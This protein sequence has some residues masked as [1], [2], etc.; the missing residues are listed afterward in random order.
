ML[1]L[2]PPFASDVEDVAVAMLL[3]VEPAGVPEAINT[4]SVNCA[5]P[6]GNE[7]IEQ[8]IGPLLPPS[9]V[10]QDMLGPVS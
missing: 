4:L 5:L 10:V 8:L 3:M 6:T 9:G 2:L 1:L 7:A